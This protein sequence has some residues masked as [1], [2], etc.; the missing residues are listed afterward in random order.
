MMSRSSKPEAVPV[1]ALPSRERL[2]ELVE[3]GVAAGR[4]IARKSL[5]RVLVGDLEDRALGH[6]DEVARERLVAVHGD[7]I[8]YDARSRRRS[9][10]LSRTMRAYWR[11]LPTAGTEP[12]SRSIAARPPT[13]SSSPACLRCSTSVSASTGSPLV[14][15]VEHRLRRSPVRLAVEVVRVQALVDDQR[16]AAPCPRA[17]RRRGPTARPRG[18]AAARAGRR[19]GGPAVVGEPCRGCGRGRSWRAIESRSLPRRRDGHSCY[20]RRVVRERRGATTCG[21]VR[22]VRATSARRPSS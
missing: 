18:S 2:L 10:A 1:I 7:W 21:G 20:S 8:S 12:A 15:Q 14:V 3:L 13:A 16:R 4:S 9:I 17:G 5:R 11:T 19:I 6:V 22:R